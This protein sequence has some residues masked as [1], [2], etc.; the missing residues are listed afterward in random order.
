MSSSSPV[1]NDKDP[2][3]M[4]LLPAPTPVTNAM[5]DE[6]AS[7]CIQG[8]LGSSTSPAPTSNAV[9]KNL[10]SSK[11]NSSTATNMNKQQADDVVA[12][13]D[14]IGV[15]AVPSTHENLN[16][17]CPRPSTSIIDTDMLVQIAAPP[18]ALGLI[19]NSN[20]SHKAGIFVA[21]IA[22]TSVMKDQIS[23]GDELI[24]VDGQDVRT[25][26]SAD[27]AKIMRAKIDNPTRMLSIIP[28]SVAQGKQEVSAG[29]SSASA[30]SATVCMRI[31]RCSCCHFSF[32]SIALSSPILTLLLMIQY[33]RSPRNFHPRSHLLFRRL[34]RNRVLSAKKTASN[35]SFRAT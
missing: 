3:A 30:A 34:F 11:D 31:F 18:G 2:T 25:L 9:S 22:S 6:I 14:V 19:L 32:Q 20:C 16:H 1:V 4:P 33:S 26:I 24:A 8:L 29:P 10:E 5:C 7:S 21:E 35:P 17:H 15:R 13:A 27:V 23:I 12:D 28:V